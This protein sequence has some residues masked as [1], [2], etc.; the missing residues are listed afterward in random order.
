MHVC[1]YACMAFQVCFPFTSKIAAN[2][3][4]LRLGRFA[5]LV[6]AQIQGLCVTGRIFSFCGFD[7]SM[8]I[9]RVLLG[10]VR[11]VQLI[12]LLLN[13]LTDFYCLSSV[14]LLNFCHL[15]F[16]NR[17]NRNQ[18]CGFRAFLCDSIF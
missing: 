17:D 13:V 3:C 14:A 7:T 8:H 15:P 16:L 2:H 6:S 1:V 4:L 9:S 18:A 5:L 11:T 10:A 12:A